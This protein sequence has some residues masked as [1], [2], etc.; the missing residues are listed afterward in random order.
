[1]LFRQAGAFALPTATIADAAL[2]L[3]LPAGSYTAQVADRRERRPPESPS[4]SAY[5]ALEG[6]VALAEV[7]SLVPMPAHNLVRGGQSKTRIGSAKSQLQL[8]S[9]LPPLTN[10]TPTVPN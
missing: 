6:K 1:M 7:S 10:T 2:L 8:R 3:S 4:S 9:W 5:G